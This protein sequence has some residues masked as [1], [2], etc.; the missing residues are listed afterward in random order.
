MQ[1]RNIITPEEIV[2]ELQNCKRFQPISK[3]EN[4]NIFLSTQKKLYQRYIKNPKKYF[5][6]NEQTGLVA[7]KNIS[8]AYANNCLKCEW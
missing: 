5:W 1:N 2:F 6:K 8:Q 7:D 4:E 3:E